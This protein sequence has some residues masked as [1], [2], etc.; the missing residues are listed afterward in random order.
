MKKYLPR[1]YDDVLKWRLESKG[2][3]LV[4]GPKWCGK[5]TT[6]EQSAKS[7]VYM[8]DPKSKEQNLRL[9]Q[10]DPSRL[11]EG[12]APR[13]VDE[14]QVAPCLWDAVR[15]EVD[16]RDGFGQFI[17]TGS[18]V[19]ADLGKVDHSGTGRIAR[20][21][22]RP[23]ALQESGD[24][25]GEVSLARLFEGEEMPIAKANG[26]LEDL[27]FLTCRG[28][29]PKAVG[30]SERVAL[31]QAFD[32]VDAVAEVDISR[33]DGVSRN[34]HYAK[35]LLRSYARMISSQGAL[36]SLQADMREA[37][38]GLGEAA[39]SEYVEALRKLFVVEDLAAWNPNLR[40]KTAIRTSPTRHFADPSIAT[41][42]LGAS[43]SELMD[44]LRTFGLIFESLCVRDLRAYSAALDGE[45]FHYRDKTGLECDAV[46]RL[47]NGRYGLVEVK[48]GGDSLINEGAASLR[49]LAGRIDT[50]KMRSPSFLMVL[51]GTGEYSYPREDGVLVVPVRTLGA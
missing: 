11:L 23:M 15:Y 16:R 8:Q 47:R 18:S 4:E 43:P 40:S 45:V 33:V 9:A 19:P 25:S 21:R 51:T 22:M 31:Q 42:A 24:S 17:L 12:D 34:G 27:A 37:G 7:I 32:Y 44:D 41:A 3:I 46:V 36:T 26:S 10:L 49:K 50:G 28:G 1:V 30:C 39:V 6:A 48:L 29:W 2:A 20:M 14:W 5:T 35:I 38:V 13:L